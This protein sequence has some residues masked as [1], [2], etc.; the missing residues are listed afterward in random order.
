MKVKYFSDTDLVYIE[1]SNQEVA[2]TKGINGNILIDL[3]ENGQLV[4]LTIEHAKVQANHSENSFL[5]L[6]PKS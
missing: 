3:V 4:G 2:E 5:Q 1:F 6:T